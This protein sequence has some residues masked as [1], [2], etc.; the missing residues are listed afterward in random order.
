[1]R[2]TTATAI[3]VDTWLTLLHQRGHIHHA[4]FESDGAWSVQRRRHSR[5]WTLLH[6]VL[7]MDWIEEIL[8][9]VH[10]QDS[11]TSR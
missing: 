4:R 1:M 7:A 2:T 9:D 3:E 8:R 6:P 5:P 11:E 10:Q